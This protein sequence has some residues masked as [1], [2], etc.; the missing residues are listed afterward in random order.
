MHFR[1]PQ[2]RRARRPSQNSDSDFDQSDGEDVPESVI[3][4]IEIP[5]SPSHPSS[6]RIGSTPGMRAPTHIDFTSSPHSPRSLYTSGSAPQ[7]QQR[8]GQQNGSKWPSQLY[9]QWF[10]A[11]AEGRSIQV[12]SILA[13]HP[14]VLNMRRREPTPFHMALTHIASEWLGNDTSGM[15]GLQVAIM[16]YKNAYANWRL[17]NGPQTEQMAGMSADQMKE[18][19]AVREVILGAL[20]DAISP[21]QLDTHFFGRQ[22]NTTLHLAAF[23]NDANLVERLLRQGAAVDISN[24]MGFQPT[25]ITNDKPTL[26][27]LA[28]YRG[29]VRGS[30]YTPAPVPPQHYTPESDSALDQFHSDGDGENGLRGSPMPVPHSVEAELELESLEIF[31]DEEVSE[32]S[33]IKQFADS[34]RSLQASNQQ[35]EHHSDELEQSDGDQPDNVSTVSSNDRCSLG[36]GGSG[37]ALAKRSLEGP[38]LRKRALESSKRPETSDSR[39]HSRNSSVSFS[40]D[41]AQLSPMSQSNTPSVMSYHTA[42]GTFSDGPSTPVTANTEDGRAVDQGPSPDRSIRIKVDPNSIMDNEID[43]IFSDDDEDDGVVQHEPSYC[44]SGA[45]LSDAEFSRSH[46]RPQP[47]QLSMVSSKSS[48]ASINM[49]SLSNAMAKAAIAAKPKS[50]AISAFPIMIHEPT[51]HVVDDSGKPLRSDQLKPESVDKGSQQARSASPFMLRD[52]LYEMIMGRSNSRLSMSSINSANSNALSNTSTVG[53]SKES[54]QQ[55]TNAQ[56]C[57]PTS[58]TSHISPTSTSFEEGNGSPSHTAISSPTD[59]F[60]FNTESKAPVQVPDAVPE[61]DESAQLPPRPTF[62]ADDYDDSSSDDSE[63]GSHQNAGFDSGSIGVAAVPRPTAASLFAASQDEPLTPVDEPAS[64]VIADEPTSPE[65]A[66]ESASPG[67]AYESASPGIADEP[68]SPVIADEPELPVLSTPDSAFRAGRIGR[69]LG[70]ETVEIMQ[71]DNVG[72]VA[73]SAKFDFIA[74]KDMEPESPLLEVGA[75]PLDVPLTRDKRD[76]YLQTLINRNTVRSASPSKRATH[77][78]MYQAMRSASPGGSDGSDDAS[79]SPSQSATFRQRHASKRSEGAIDFRSPSALG[80][81]ERIWDPESMPRP[82]SSAAMREALSVSGASINGRMRSNTMNTSSSSLK[83][84][85]QTRKVSPSLATLKTRN[86][87]SNSPAK[88]TE[89]HDASPLGLSPTRQLKLIDSRTRAMSTPVDAQPPSLKLPGAESDVPTLPRGGASSAR[90]GRVAALSQNF[91]R[92]QQK[93]PGWGGSRIVI[94]SRASAK[95][96]ASKDSG[97]LGVVSAPLGNANTLFRRPVARSSSMSSSHSAGGHGQPTSAS[98]GQGQ[99]GSSKNDP[100]QSAQDHDEQPADED[101]NDGAGDSNGGA[102][103]GAG[104]SGQG[105]GGDDSSSD[106]KPSPDPRAAL[107]EPLES[108]DSSSSSHASSS[109]TGRGLAANIRGD[110]PTVLFGSAGSSDNVG[111]SIFSSTESRSSSGAEPLAMSE[112]SNLHAPVSARRETETER[113]RRFKELAKRRKSGTLE[114]ISNSGVV[115][116]RQALFVPS[117]PNLR[118]P[119]SSPKRSRVQFVDAQDTENTSFLGRRGAE[120]RPPDSG[121]DAMPSSLSSV[122]VDLERLHRA[123]VPTLHPHESPLTRES[124]VRGGI[125]ADAVLERTLEQA[126][127]EATQSVQDASNVWSHGSDKSKGG[128]SSNSGRSKNGGSGSGDDS[129]HIL[130]SFDTNSTPGSTPMDSAQDS[131]KVGLLAQYDMDQRRVDRRKQKSMRD[132]PPAADTRSDVGDTQVLEFGSNSDDEENPQDAAFG[133]MMPSRSRY[134][135]QALFG[136]STVAEVE[137]E[138]RVPSVEVSEAAR[139]THEMQERRTSAGSLHGL[140][141]ALGPHMAVAPIY[142][143]LG[144]VSIPDA[145]EELVSPLAAGVTQEALDAALM[146][147]G[148]ASPRAEIDDDTQSHAP[149]IGSHSFDPYL[150]FGYTSEDNSTMASRSSLER[151][152]IFNMGRPGS[153][154][155][156]VMY[157]HPL[158]TPEP[159]IATHAPVASTSRV[160]GRRLY[161][162]GVSASMDR[163]SSEYDSSSSSASYSGKG[164]AVQRMPEMQQIDPLD[165]LPH[166]PV[167]TIDEID[168]DAS[169]DEEPINP[170]LFVESQDF[171]GYVPVGRQIQQERDERRQE[172][173]RKKE[174]ARLGITLPEEEPEEVISPLWFEENPYIDPLPP[175]MLQ[176]MVEKRDQLM[177]KK[178]SK[179]RTTENPDL[180]RVLDASTISSRRLREELDATMAEPV[181]ASRGTIKQLN[182]RPRTSGISSMFEPPASDDERADNEEPAPSGPRRRSKRDQ[183][184]SF[185][186]SVEIPISELS[187]DTSSEDGEA[188]DIRG[189]IDPMLLPLISQEFQA[190]DERYRPPE[191]DPVLAAGLPRK[192]LVLRTQ[193]KTFSQRVLHEVD[194]LKVTV[195]DDV[196]GSVRVRS[197]GQ[198]AFEPAAGTVR[199]ATMPQYVSALDGVP[200]GPFFMPPRAAAKAGYLYMRILSIE[201][202]DDP[203]SSVYFVIRNGIDTLATTPVSV[204]GVAGTT[205]NQEFRILTDPDISITMWMRFRSDAII[206]RNGRGQLNQPGCMPPLLRKLVRRNTRSRANRWQCNSPNDSVFDFTSAQQRFDAGA[207]RGGPVM[208][209]GIVGRQRPQPQGAQFPERVSSAFISQNPNQHSPDRGNTQQ[210]QAANDPR[211]LN[212]TQAPSSVYYEPGVDTGNPTSSHKGLAEARFKEET[213]GVAVVHIGEMIE[214]VFLRGLVDSWDV[215]NVW[216]NRKGAR[217]S[218]QLFFI[219]ECPLFREDELPKTLSEC[220]MA[221]EVCGFHNRTLNSGYMSQRGGDTRFWRRRYFRLIGGFLF[222]YHEETKEPRCF[223]DLNDATRVVDLQA[224]RTRHP[225]PAFGQLDLIRTHRMRR[226]PT[227]K[228]NHSDYSSRDGGASERGAMA[229]GHGYA[230]DSEPVDMVDIADPVLQQSSIRRKQT[231]RRSSKSA[232]KTA[233]NPQTDSGVFSQS[234]VVGQPDNGMQH[235]FS[236]EFGSGGLVEFYTETEEEKRV[237]VEIVKRVVGNIPKIPSWLIKLLH[238]DVSERIES[239]APGASDSSLGNVSVPSSKFQ[240]MTHPHPHMQ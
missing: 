44:N 163:P 25:G 60:S 109:S 50:T 207:R 196:H 33:Y 179:H 131:M 77:S 227:H 29:Q 200:A 186:D 15:D 184:R 126:H 56:P 116:N 133:T 124:S 141:A 89:P 80:S 48:S 205:I 47:L 164:K 129:L 57:S 8:F 153:S 5:K 190:N 79:R 37:P 136:L 214:E 171:E 213:R 169:S 41:T 72:S 148:P 42:N 210:S 26:Q 121:P 63:R 40:S 139:S 58:P 82:S 112:P 230:S 88:S 49:Q 100:D 20:I 3:G 146:G 240:E 183:R 86:L 13:D 107:L 178:I 123:N 125:D 34:A 105:D 18:H 101:I 143:G 229:V 128:S 97:D 152:D 12:H 188:D 118:M 189:P 168:A 223:I 103:G 231:Q 185:L 187:S 226:R 68:T 117:E 74:S 65:I 78:A 104:N 35:A 115:K 22:Q 71:D 195:R 233:S 46:A 134:N 73:T 83:P 180:K 54:Q 165:S 110:S 43:D 170:L 193:P 177:V 138:S 234:S 161:D 94:P 239:A 93:Q 212:A 228:R 114:K 222:A 209:P 81:R 162:S 175:K 235:S 113:R 10:G 155:S 156:R 52:S 96:M 67:I 4:P 27:W 217:L 51:Q 199:P 197:A 145:N 90:I 87:V 137:D 16:G 75:L 194:E 84:T 9:K 167:P 135:P 208:R 59:N 232:S 198:F 6:S 172:R 202:I 236:I 92:Q 238:A 225:E 120:T 91:E 142:R 106:G 99:R 69:R 39:P 203:P 130:S 122:D 211:S 24:R 216:E 38:N 221:M 181:T 174:A 14:E 70:R 17:G 95:A 147:A 158:D 166:A 102:A 160:T 31:S 220:E 19:V 176:L 159:E 61:E 76:Q 111:S 28:M 45:G 191:Y 55:N 215:E 206:Y 140:R 144:S 7:Q 53:A 150:V 154:A 219:P 21:E 218:L 204:G 157:M 36:L 192:R 224:E 127:A 108:N 2:P 149:S 66:Y 30:R 98:S 201:D 132:A 151:S 1:Q 182:K 85:A 23:Y 237:W 11:I 62:N 173:R 64:P 119:T 32:S